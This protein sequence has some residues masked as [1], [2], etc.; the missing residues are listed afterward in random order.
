VIFRFP[1]GSREAS[2]PFHLS[3]VATS[4]N[5]D[6]GGGLLRRMQH[7]VNGLAEQARRHRLSIELILV[8]WNPPP[9]R[10]PLADALRWP[11]PRTN[12][13]IRIITVPSALHIRLKHADQLP[14][15]QMIAKNVGIRRARG[16]Y[17]LATNI[18]I[19]FSDS[20]MRY[21][22]DELQPG[23]LYRADRCDV[24]T[25]VPEGLPIEQV[26]LFC[27]QA[28]FRINTIGETL[29]KVHGRWRHTPSGSR[30]PMRALHRLGHAAALALGT[31]LT[32]VS[33]SLARGM[34]ELGRRVGALPGRGVRRLDAAID[35]F[36]RRARSAR[37]RGTRALGRVRRRLGVA[38]RGLRRRVDPLL[39]AARPRL[40][41][42]R[43][44]HG[45]R[46]LWRRT[47]RRG[48]RG[49]LRSA[50]R[51]ARYRGLAVG[52]AV[53]RTAGA[54]PRVAASASR[55]G[56]GAGT[57][58]ARRVGTALVRT[59]TRILHAIIRRAVLAGRSLCRMAQA[60]GQP[61]LRTARVVRR[62]IATGAAASAR[63]L[64]RW[65]DRTRAAM[66]RGALR[67]GLR[68]DDRLF[69]NAC[70]DFTLLS[71]ADWFELRGYPEWEMF[72]W[73]IDSVLLYQA[74]RNGLRE[75]YA[76]RHRPIFHIEHG[77]GSGY[78][79]EG[80]ANLF[81]RLEARGI[82]YIS[83]P[84]FLS[85]VADMDAVRRRGEPVVYNTASWG[86]ADEE[87]PEQTITGDA[88][89]ANGRALRQS[90]S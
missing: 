30:S 32:S 70:G 50:R 67:L 44:R 10:P 66:A 83:W 72:S 41:A 38:G 37:G 80:A 55:R 77:T 21:L 62:Q 3:V 69:T 8:E 60:I 71:R 25:D 63:T 73:H 68:T 87:L 52:R 35:R 88:E 15:F 82:P 9:D 5:D 1:S 81:A 13:V 28:M 31:S 6:H 23:W 59:A 57:R 89:A 78:T 18:D 86:L 54:V 58:A 12:C 85:L 24:P 14:L 33:T 65:R 34:T 16:R 36:D 90:V 48:L 29:V 7:F 76:G 4:R 53:S 45:S 64:M 26:L 20:M 40:V 39:A 27:Q 49:S 56:W 61:V 17:V 22:R 74:N 79:P 51:F 2:R 42:A 84:D 43:C 46:R 11:E 19:L 75:A 47:R